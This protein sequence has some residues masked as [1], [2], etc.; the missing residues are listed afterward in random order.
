[1]MTEILTAVI[2]VAIIGLICA[3]VL[4]VASKIMA[5]KENEKIPVIRECLPGANCGACGYAGCD[6][7]AKALAEG[8]TEKTNLCIPGGAAT[9]MK[10]SEILGVDFEDVVE[11][12]AVVHCTGDCNY[13]KDRV[14]YSAIE[15]CTAAK[16]IFGSKGE[17]PYGCMGLGDCVKVCPN[18]AICIENGIAHINTRMCVGCGLCKDACPNSLISLIDDDEKVIIA[19]SN[20]DKGAVTRKACTSGCIGCRKCVKVCPSGAISIVDN[21]AVID[22][23][24]CPSCEDFGICAR[25]CTTGCIL[26]SDLT[27]MRRGK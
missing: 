27:G 7:Y 24:K 10:I 2:P 26:I 4:V 14:E 16:M 3:V 20:K 8:E 15:S 12:V 25:E 23:L 22:Y 19:C 1:M 18:D 6:G 13:T 9:S 11:K 21:L 5:V 17:C